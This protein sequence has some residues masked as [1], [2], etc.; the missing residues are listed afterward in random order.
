MR[1]FSQRSQVSQTSVHFQSDS[2]QLEKEDKAKLKRWIKRLSKHRIESISLKGH[3]DSDADSSYNVKLSQKRVAEVKGY[4]KSFKIGNPRFNTSFHGEEVPVKS[5]LSEYGKLANRRVDISIAYKPKKPPKPQEV[6]PEEEEKIIVEVNNV[7]TDT[8]LTFPEGSQLV[9]DKSEF[10]KRN[11][12]LE[13]EEAVSL[14]QILESGL[15]TTAFNGSPLISGGMMRVK[16]K[17]GCDSSSFNQPVKVRIPIFENDDCTWNPR[18]F[19]PFVIDENGN[20]I[21]MRKAGFRRIRVNGQLF[22]EFKVRNPNFAVNCDI[23]S[24]ETYSPKFDFPEDLQPLSIKVSSDCPKFVITQT[25][26]HKGH[27][28]RMN[29]PAYR[30][31]NY[32]VEATFVDANNDTLR[33]NPMLLNDLY[34]RKMFAGFPGPNFSVLR[35]YWYNGFFVREKSLFRKYYIFNYDLEETTISVE[36]D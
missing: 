10:N 20:W 28:F 32:V 8:I 29:L 14:N 30:S 13:M 4:L 36:K 2:Y 16:T 27:T 35:R 5:N 25:Y 7:S 24:A 12:C 31:N 19:R 23:F 33:L 6:V 18:R 11:D 15:N 22:Y 17:P 21:R 34:H 26:A 1:S 9:I 3:T